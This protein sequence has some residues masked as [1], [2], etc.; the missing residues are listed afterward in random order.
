MAEKYVA[1]TEIRHGEPA[2]DE[3]VSELKVFKEGDEVKGL[4]RE[5]MRSLWDAGALRKAE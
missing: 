3:G 5:T 2:D 4:S 1:A